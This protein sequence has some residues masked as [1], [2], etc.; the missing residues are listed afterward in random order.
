[1]DRALAQAR[2]YDPIPDS[3]D[4]GEAMRAISPQMRAFVVA[5]I[6]LGA[7]NAAQAARAARYGADSPTPEQ[8]YNTQKVSGWRLIHDDRILLAIKEL[9]AARLQSYAHKAADVLIEIMEDP[10]HKDRFAAANK[11]MAHAGLVAAAD[12]VVH[13]HRVERRDTIMERIEALAAK[14]G[15]NPEAL[16]QRRIS[17]AT[18]VTVKALPQPV[19]AVGS[20]DGLEDLL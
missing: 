6:D 4:L 9:A 2:T 12:K 11:L 19:E 17:E 5:Y 16:L 3:P 20:A 14:H 1:M 13:E 10:T 18:P 8:A 15:L 7:K